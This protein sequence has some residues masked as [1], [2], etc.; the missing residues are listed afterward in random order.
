[1]TE[2]EIATKKARAAQ[3][4]GVWYDSRADRFAA[5]V[6]SCG[7]RHFL[8]LYGTADEAADAYATARAS[9]PTGRKT[10]TAF[11][12]AFAAMLDGCPAGGPT[13][14]SALEYDGQTFTF[15]RLAFTQARG[16][17]RPLFEWSSHCTDCGAAYTTQTATSPD[18]ARGVTRRCAAHAK[19]GRPKKATATEATQDVVAAICRVA[20]AL[21][22]IDD[23]VPLTVFTKACRE[24]GAAIPSG[25]LTN[26][27]RSPVTIE[28]TDDGMSC[29]FR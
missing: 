6:Y 25:F 22:L 21:S 16:K 4:R 20:D 28:H 5:E 14:G 10:G 9:L 2:D 12:A 23:A 26:N 24:A 27:P 11:S 7:K 3:H 29:R 8:G 1:V 15:E 18:V 17:R 13:K 19:G